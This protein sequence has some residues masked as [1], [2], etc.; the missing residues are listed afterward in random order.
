MPLAGTEYSDGSHGTRMCFHA[1]TRTNTIVWMVK[2]ALRW[3][4]LSLCLIPAH[5][6]LDCA[7]LMQGD[8]R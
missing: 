3:R 4:A 2:V 1:D 6:I 7:S 8:F 5:L